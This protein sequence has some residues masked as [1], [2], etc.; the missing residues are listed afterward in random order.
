MESSMS[1]C[2][3]DTQSDIQHY[4]PNNLA[5]NI[6]ILFN[7]LR[8][9]MSEDDIKVYSNEKQVDNLALLT[10]AQLQHTSQ[11]KRLTL[12]DRPLSMCCVS[13]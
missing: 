3:R 5:L 2:S 12:I 4:H 7:Q 9:Y 8:I 6:C 1:G 10:F 11:L 13:Y